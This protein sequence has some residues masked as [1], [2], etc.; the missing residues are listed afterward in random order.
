MSPS[1]VLAP[2]VIAAFLCACAPDRAPALVTVHNATSETVES[3][4][5]DVSKQVLQAEDLRPG[6]SVTLNYS[7]GLESDYHVVATLKAGRIVEKHVGY[8][9]AGLN[10]HDLIIVRDADVEFRGLQTPKR[11]A[12]IEAITSG[13]P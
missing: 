9:D 13:F 4:A 5:I 8:V 7:I 2:V 10:A 3:V 11:L 12:G 6:S 1:A